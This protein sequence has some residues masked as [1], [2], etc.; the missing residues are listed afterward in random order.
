MLDKVIPPA[1]FNDDDFYVFWTQTKQLAAHYSNK[2]SKPVPLPGQQ[3]ATG[4]S[5]KYLGLWK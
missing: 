4:L 1:S 2:C 5:A 3:V